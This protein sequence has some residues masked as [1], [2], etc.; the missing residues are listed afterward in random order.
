MESRVVT[1]RLKSAEVGMM[2]ELTRHFGKTEDVSAT[3]FFRL[4][5]YREWNRRKGLG[6]VKPSSW[7]ADFRKGRPRGKRNT[8]L[9]MEGEQQEDESR[10]QEAGGL[11]KTE[12]SEL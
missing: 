3:E 4:L 5:L 12:S 6:K 2:E 9:I 8:D 10:P 11:V 1:I 7:Q